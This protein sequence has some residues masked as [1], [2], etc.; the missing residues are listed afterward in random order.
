M[1]IKD[2]IMEG[3]NEKINA[4]FE[5]MNNKSLRGSVVAKAISETPIDE[6]E[7][8]ELR[9]KAYADAF[10]GEWMRKGRI[11]EKAINYFES[12]VDA[13]GGYAVPQTLFD[14]IIARAGTVNVMRDLATIYK[15]S[16][17]SMEL[18][19]ELEADGF[20]AEWSGE[21]D[22]KGD[23]T[24]TGFEKV[25][26]ECFDIYAKP[27]ATLRNLSDNAFNLESYI[28]EKIG[29]AF[30]KKTGN[31]Y[32]L[33]DGTGKPTGLLPAITATGLATASTIT[34]GELN[35]LLYSL[36][37][38]YADNG[39][40]LMSRK[41]LGAINSIV[42]TQG[43][44]IFRMPEVRQEG[45]KVDGY[46]LNYPVRLDDNMPDIQTAVANDVVIAFGDFR[47]A[48]AI[49]DHDG[50]FQ[51]RDTLTETGFVK[52]PTIMRTGGKPVLPEAVIGL[53]QIA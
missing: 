49:V 3:L 36:K 21:S 37:Q 29:M 50:M 42:D 6:I 53:K 8:K 44:P 20:Q 48:Y 22:A 13:N 14:K 35:T 45:S 52:F 30:G 10:V 25:T 46:L 40:W 5:E 32:L 17:N 51:E 7:D 9:Q 26:L 18:V 4:K 34:F 12:A 38:E 31:A 11:T 23:S 2:E 1:N 47:R 15:T 33:G 27:K 24:G 16:T 41:T 39:V 19:V 28:I 43:Q